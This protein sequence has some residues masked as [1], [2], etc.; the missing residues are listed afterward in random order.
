MSLVASL[1]FFFS[2][3]VSNAIGPII[4]TMALI[5]SFLIISNL[6]LDILKE[7]KPYFFTTYLN[8][9]Q[10]FFEQTL[11]MTAILN[12]VAILSAHIAGLFLLTYYFFRKK[13]I[14]T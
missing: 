5:V 12:A 4:S 9:W 10:L 6:P 11:N 2:S 7:A 1:A 3:I 8:D 14:L 13:D